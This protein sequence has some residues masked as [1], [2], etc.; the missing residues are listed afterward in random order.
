MKHL[1]GYVSGVQFE[2]ISDIEPLMEK[3]VDTC[4]LT[5]VNRAFHQFEP[6]GVTGVLVLSESHF[7]VHTY[8]EDNIVY[9]DIF[10]CSADFDPEHAGRVILNTFNGTHAAWQVIHRK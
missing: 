6:F 10:C 5:V 2:R 9:V 7:S 8:P 1:V 4:N 3:I